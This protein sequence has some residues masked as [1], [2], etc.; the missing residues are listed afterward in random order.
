MGN[1]LA[2]Q[3][4]GAISTVGVGDPV[5]QA[6]RQIVRQRNRRLQAYAIMR[7]IFGGLNTSE[8]NWMGA[9]KAVFKAAG[10]WFD[11]DTVAT[12]VEDAFLAGLDAR[13]G[14]SLEKFLGDCG[15][16]AENLIL[17]QHV[18]RVLQKL[19]SLCDEKV[20]QHAATESGREPHVDRFRSDLRDVIDTCRNAHHAEQ[21]R[22]ELR[23]ESRRQFSSY[24]GLID[25]S[26]G[27]IVPL[28]ANV[29][30]VGHTPTLADLDGVQ[31]AVLEGIQEVA[32]GPFLADGPN[33]VGRP[34]LS[35]F[36]ANLMHRVE[37]SRLPR[38]FKRHETASNIYGK[39]NHKGQNGSRDGLLMVGPRVGAV[40]SFDQ[41]FVPYSSAPNAIVIPGAPTALLQNRP[42][43]LSVRD[44]YLDKHWPLAA[45]VDSRER[46]KAF[47]RK[48]DLGACICLP[49]VLD[50]GAE[51]G[52]VVGV[53]NVN[54]RTAD[55]EVV[56]Q[57]ESTGALLVI[58]DILKPYLSMLALVEAR[59]R[60]G[61]I[62]NL[63][64]G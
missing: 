38:R 31:T 39:I 50:S 47:L 58:H 28:M 22:T 57:L 32:K 25:E 9:T 44:E 26:L 13:D 60:A 56:E 62:Y 49:V 52:K 7:D 61:S 42:T 33:T 63:S 15:E 64:G 14:F 17:P 30:K 5:R 11:Q 3:S 10:R 46:L 23:V 24:V 55:A 16:K 41:F 36:G 29:L 51:A 19:E 18:V 27:H 53:V 35:N 1:E 34:N 37:Y 40:E 6:V 21:Q 45:G 43:I 12:F 20:V 59:R 4:P 54:S 2:R 8:L 48:S